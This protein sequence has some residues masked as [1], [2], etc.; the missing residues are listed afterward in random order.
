MRRVLAA[1]LLCCGLGAIA[2]AQLLSPIV[3]FGPLRAT[4]QGPGD[5]ASG[6]TAFF[7]CGRAYNAAYAAAHSPAC[8]VVDTA[9]GLTTCTF[10]FLSTGFV[11]PSACNATACATA[12]SVTKMY[13]QTG[14]G[15]HAVQATLASMPPL[16][17]SAQN[18]LPCLGPSSP[19]KSVATS[20]SIA[21]TA[22]YSVTLVAERTANFTTQSIITT[23]AATAGR[24]SFPAIANTMRYNS[25]AVASLTVTDAAP[26]ALVGVTSAVDPLFAADSSANTVTTTNGTNSLASTFSIQSTANNVCEVGIWPSDL[27]STYQAMLANMRSAT[28]GWNF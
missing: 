11:S 24:M 25:G 26:H 6:A 23:E 12:C 20:T 9:T 15:N 5:I 10:S 13:D 18:S 17:L 16:N 27:N 2:H 3:N 1:F 28:N 7:S 21:Q 8:D 22:P 19:A 14:N 4:Y